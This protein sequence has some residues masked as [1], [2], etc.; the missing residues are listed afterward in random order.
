VVAATEFEEV[1]GD[2]QDVLAARHSIYLTRKHMA[3]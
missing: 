1:F 3:M 2:N